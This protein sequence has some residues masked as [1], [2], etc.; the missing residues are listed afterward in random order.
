MRGKRHTRACAQATSIPM[1]TQAAMHTRRHADMPT[2]RHAHWPWTRTDRHAQT[3]H[4]HTQGHAH[5]QTCTHKAHAHR[6]TCT[7]KS[8][9]HRQTCAHKAHAHT[10]TCTPTHLLHEEREQLQ[11]QPPSLLHVEQLEGVAEHHLLLKLLH[12]LRVGQGLVAQESCAIQAS[13]QTRGGVGRGGVC[14]IQRWGEG[15]RSA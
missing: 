12:C 9:T 5:R 15:R 10:R 11:V 8:H 13:E 4:M 7:H 2:C 3:K 6:Q 1:Y 14:N